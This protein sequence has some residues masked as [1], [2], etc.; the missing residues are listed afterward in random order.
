TVGKNTPSAMVTIFE[1]SPMPNQMMNS[2]TNAILGI[3]NSAA[4]T[5][6]TEDRVDDQSPAAMPKPTPKIVPANQPI[7]RRNNDAE[8]CCHSTPETL[9]F[10]SATPIEAGDGRNR[11]G[12]SPVA[13]P[14]CQNSR[15]CTKVAAPANQ[16]AFG[17]KPPPRNGTRL[18]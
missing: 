9:K 6:M 7:T 10:Q 12:I 17:A 4:T 14:T 3:G 18:S 2:G 13:A 5:A 11:V 16:V 1:P 8:T 15:I